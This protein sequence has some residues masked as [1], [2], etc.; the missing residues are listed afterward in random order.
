MTE[1]PKPKVCLKCNR[2]NPGERK[3]CITCE[4]PLDKVI[5]VSLDWKTDNLHQTG[6]EIKEDG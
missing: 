4:F 2:L 1:R 3:R 6:K 5:E